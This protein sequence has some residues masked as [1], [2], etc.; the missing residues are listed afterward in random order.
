[1]DDVP[2][3]LKG[4]SNNDHLGCSQNSIVD[5][6]TRYCKA[7]LS[8]LWIKVVREMVENKEKIRLLTILS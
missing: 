2:L 4:K 3:S 5:S 8:V 7:S 6:I 1:M